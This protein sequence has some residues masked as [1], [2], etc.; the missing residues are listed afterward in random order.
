M[1]ADLAILRWTV[2]HGQESVLL[3]TLTQGRARGESGLSAD[4]V[5]FHGAWQALTRGGP[6]D[7]WCR[8]CGIK[9]RLFSG[10][11]PLGEMGWNVHALVCPER[12]VMTM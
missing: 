2:A 8:Q 3:M 10:E 4:R 1:V 7:R 9:F 11:S 5:R 12:G 6:W